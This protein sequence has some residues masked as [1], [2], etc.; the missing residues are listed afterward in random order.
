MMV[1]YY[2]SLLEERKKA[3]EA[4]TTKEEQY[5]AL[6]AVN[7]CLKNLFIEK[8]NIYKRLEREKPKDICDD[9]I[10]RGCKSSIATDAVILAI[11]NVILKRDGLTI[12][13]AFLA[14]KHKFE[15]NDDKLSFDVTKRNPQKDFSKSHRILGLWLMI[16]GAAIIIVAFALSLLFDTFSEE[17]ARA[18]GKDHYMQILPV[19]ACLSGII[20]F[21]R[22]LYKSISGL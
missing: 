3:V 21:F 14:A 10:R 12:N 19:G 20:C 18:S 4:A 2:I 8:Y 11:Q 17:S 16:G 13:Q 15:T 1:N 9:I 22:G 6:L 7:E 5:K